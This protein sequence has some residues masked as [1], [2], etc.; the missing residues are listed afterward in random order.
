MCCKKYASIR[1]LHPKPD[2]LRARIELR[3]APLNATPSEVCGFGQRC[4]SSE[5]PAPAAQPPTPA[6]KAHQ[7]G[8]ESAYDDRDFPPAALLDPPS[9]LSPIIWFPSGPLAPLW[10]PYSSVNA[11][12]R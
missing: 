1:R 11:D 4:Q 2:A 5:T 8:K 6:L 10:I 7:K 3:V 9:G 12:S